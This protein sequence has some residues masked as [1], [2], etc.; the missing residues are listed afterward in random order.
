MSEASVILDG[1]PLTADEALQLLFGGVPSQRAERHVKREEGE[2]DGR[3]RRATLLRLRNDLR[4]EAYFRGE[5]IDPAEFEGPANRG[6]P[7]PEEIAERAAEIRAEWSDH[8]RE[9]RTVAAFRRSGV[10]FS[11]TYDPAGRESDRAA[12]R[13]LLYG[14][15][16]DAMLAWSRRVNDERGDS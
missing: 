12:M 7:S 10:V 3:E 16:P 15:K 9:L 13:F 1:R 6:E 5:A 4:L 8:E 11:E 2:T 14:G